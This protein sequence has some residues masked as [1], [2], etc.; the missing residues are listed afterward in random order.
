M[1]KID[2]NLLDIKGVAFDVDGVLS[3]NVI[4]MSVDGTPLRMINLKDGYALKAAVRS[5][6]L[7]AIISGAD[8]E[9][10]RKRFSTL[11]IND[12]YLKVATKID[13]LDEW[14]SKH[15]LHRAE[16]A[17]VG[18][19]IPDYE[20]MKHV[21]LPVAPAD[22][23]ADIKEVARYISPCDGGYGVARDFLEEVLRARGQWVTH[24]K[25]FGW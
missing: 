20:C 12:I 19:D 9:A 1:S 5:G 22:A 6:L 13:C 15:G 4:P 11:G 23:A 25:A 18:D 7:I 24:A 16:V 14:M 21:G 2:Y 17:F 8:G 10:L 3:P